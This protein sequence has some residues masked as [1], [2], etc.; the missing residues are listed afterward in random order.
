MS[1]QK[2]ARVA[3]ALAGLAALTSSNVVMA[4]VHGSVGVFI[5]PGFAS[6]YPYAY[7]YPYPY[8]GYY[9]PPVV[10]R[11]AAPPQYIEQGADGR[12]VA[13][14]PVSGPAPAQ[15]G[16]QSGAPGGAQGSEYP[17]PQP[18]AQPAQGTWFHCDRPEGYYPYIRNCP[19]GWRKVPAQP[20]A[21]S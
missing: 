3:L 16:S 4:G 5:G 10:V 15:S 18:G 19:G 14:P 17:G 9:Y 2:I 8:P 11:P 12:P 20:P 21:N 6:P 7:P 1:R 13:V